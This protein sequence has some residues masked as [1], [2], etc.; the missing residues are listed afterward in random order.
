MMCGD[1]RVFNEDSWRGNYGRNGHPKAGN[2]VPIQGEHLMSYR[3][4]VKA[5]L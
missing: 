3:F 4:L 1:L 5:E 2:F